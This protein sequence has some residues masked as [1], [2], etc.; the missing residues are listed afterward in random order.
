M[1]ANLSILA[2]WV[3]VFFRKCAE[4]FFDRGEWTERDENVDFILEIPS[5]LCWGLLRDFS[6][7]RFQIRICFS[8][9]VATWW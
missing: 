2:R 3:S 7:S 4:L 9:P 1:I 5:I 8:F 6:E